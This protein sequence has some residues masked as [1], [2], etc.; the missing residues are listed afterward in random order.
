LIN[1]FQGFRFAPA[2]WALPPLV[3]RKGQEKGKVDQR[4]K[5]VL[6]SDVLL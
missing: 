4:S 3:A 6:T 1:H 5:K 2:C